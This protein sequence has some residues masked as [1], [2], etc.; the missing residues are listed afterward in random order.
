MGRLLFQNGKCDVISLNS[1]STISQ[2]IGSSTLL[3][4][5][6]AKNYYLLQIY[7]ILQANNID[8]LL[9]DLEDF[10]TNKEKIKKL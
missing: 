7:E 1:E 9:K 2:I 8:N 6:K 3:T 10:E 4:T 5:E